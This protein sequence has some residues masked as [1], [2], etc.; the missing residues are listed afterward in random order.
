MYIY[1]R[2]L[3]YI[4]QRHM[5][6]CN[7]IDSAHILS[8]LTFYLIVQQGLGGGRFLS[9]RREVTEEK[10]V[11]VW[12]MSCLVDTSG[13]TAACVEERDRKQGPLWVWEPWCQEERD[14]KTD[15]ALF[16][17]Y[18]RVDA[19]HISCEAGAGFVF[20]TRW[21]RSWMRKMIGLGV[22]GW[23]LLTEMGNGV[24]LSHKVDSLT[25]FLSSTSLRA[26]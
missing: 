24:P 16:T 21:S 11:S 20:I 10:V 7:K 3:S 15:D 23:S 1:Q 26:D 6:S 18:I 2:K 13:V 8:W 14:K 19:R 4:T 9:K 5:W 17:F 22:S 12:E 25:E